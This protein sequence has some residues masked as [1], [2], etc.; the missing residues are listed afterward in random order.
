MS[1]PWA[2]WPARAE[3]VKGA[4]YWSYRQLWQECQ[5]Q[6]GGALA[7]LHMICKVGGIQA[8]DEAT[9]TATAASAV[10]APCSPGCTPH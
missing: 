5:A 9:D 6:A 4:A 2:G 7:C 1:L 10:G 3:P 8:Q